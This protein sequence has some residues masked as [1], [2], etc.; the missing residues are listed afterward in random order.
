MFQDERSTV[1]RST[2]VMTKTYLKEAAA[3]PANVEAFNVYEDAEEIVEEGGAGEAICT[4]EDCP[5]ASIFRMASYF[6][7]IGGE[8][9][10]DYF[11]DE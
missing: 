7:R 10:L 4:H 9:F 3:D 6:D 11:V 2:A 5:A 1:P 8:D